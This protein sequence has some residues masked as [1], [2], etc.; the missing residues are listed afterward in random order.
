[1][2]EAL[3]MLGAVKFRTIAGWL[4]EFDYSALDTVSLGFLPMID[5]K[6]QSISM[7]SICAI[8]ALTLFGCNPSFAKSDQSSQVGLSTG[9]CLENEL[10]V[11]IP[12][13]ANNAGILEMVTPIVD[14]DGVELTLIP[15]EKGLACIERTQL[16]ALYRKAGLS[17]SHMPIEV[18]YDPIGETQRYR[19]MLEYWPD[20]GADEPFTISPPNDMVFGKAFW[21][22]SDTRGDLDVSWQNL[23]EITGYPLMPSHD[24]LPQSTDLAFD[25]EKNV[26]QCIDQSEGVTVEIINCQSDEIE[27]VDYELNDIY[28]IQ[29]K[30]FDASERNRLRDFQRKWIKRRDESCEEKAIA[31]GG[32]LATIV[33]N[34]CIIAE[35]VSRTNWL[36]ELD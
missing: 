17:G 33:Y 15:V 10:V 11:R 26:D 16:L 3:G 18:S 1:M 2:S 36:R 22:M 34:D 29:M 28:R 21:Q 14:T 27:R 25:S 7:P 31:V 8:F 6:L 12:S 23:E 32:S 20:I 24:N 5:R 19:S 30:E 4:F 35:T 9:K 13:K